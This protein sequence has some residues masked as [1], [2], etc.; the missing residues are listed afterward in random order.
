MKVAQLVPRRNTMPSDNSSPWGGS[1]EFIPVYNV[2][3]YPVLTVYL[4]VEVMCFMRGGV[5]YDDVAMVGTA[6]LVFGNSLQT[7]AVGLWTNDEVGCHMLTFRETAAEGVPMHIFLKGMDSS[8]ARRG[9]HDNRIA[10]LGESY[11]G[12]RSLRLLIQERLGGHPQH[13]VPG[14]AK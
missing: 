10:I 6:G 2:S 9:K 3:V 8:F 4:P 1:E 5:T 11:I 12:L 14:W 7:T 13:E